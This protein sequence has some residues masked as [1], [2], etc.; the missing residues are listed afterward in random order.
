MP[1]NKCTHF[2]GIGLDPVNKTNISFIKTTVYK[3]P[4]YLVLY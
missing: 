1:K 3:T 4:V 2:V